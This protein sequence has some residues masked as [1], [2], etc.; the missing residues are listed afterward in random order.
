VGEKMATEVSAATA[1]TEEGSL[2]QSA[3][4]EGAAGARKVIA[5]EIEAGVERGE[6]EGE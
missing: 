2:G 6:C 4:G 3:V 1:G 5:C